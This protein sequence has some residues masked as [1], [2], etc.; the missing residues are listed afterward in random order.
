M[1][2]PQRMSLKSIAQL[3]KRSSGLTAVWSNPLFPKFSARYQEAPSG[4]LRGA[5]AE[6]GDEPAGQEGEGFDA[7]FVCAM[8][9]MA[10]LLRSKQPGAVTLQDLLEFME[11]GHPV[12]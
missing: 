10:A 3:L 11:V 4:D 8:T 5:A 2:R 9:T 7:R 1:C 6:A 12:A